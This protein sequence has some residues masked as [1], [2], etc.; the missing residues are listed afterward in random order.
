MRKVK[1]VHLSNFDI[2]IQIHARNLNR[3]LRDQGYSPYAVTHPGRVIRQDT[4][5]PDG[6]PVKVIPFPSRITPFADLASL[7]KLVRY[8]RQENFDIV[9]AHTIKPGLL[10]RIAARV[11]RV[12]V[13]LY[14]I[15]GFHFH[16]QMK[17]AQIAFYG[18]IERI[19]ASL[20][21]LLLSQNQEDIRTAV[22]MSIAKPDKIRHLGNGIDIRVFHPSRVTPEL[23]KAKREE[24]RI[25]NGH[26]VVA[27]VGRLVRE[28]GFYEY[29]EAATILKRRGIPAVF[30][31][32]GAVHEKKGAVDPIG[33]IRKFGLVGYLHFLGLRHDIPDLLA[34]VDVLVSPSYAE[35]IPRN[36]MEA[37]A[38]GKPVVATDVRGTREII[39]NGVTGILVPPKDPAALAEAIQ[40]VLL[41]GEL[42]SAMGKAAR[43]KAEQMMDERAF[44][45]RTDRF[46]R[47]LLYQRQPRVDWNALLKPVPDG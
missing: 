11:A 10:G 41:D 35:G 2:G 18:F 25:P 40:K 39:E 14:T 19:G 38:M 37:C 8:F 17:P 4:V 21:D 5:T 20:S 45:I 24:L 30:L 15:H 46:Y 26:K 7:V 47:E 36:V 33:L 12:P 3:Y 42:A 16:D 43:A 44:F 1:V 6:I 29:F 13:V 9:H 32:V 23:V 31:S 28:K 22:R 27:M 34:A